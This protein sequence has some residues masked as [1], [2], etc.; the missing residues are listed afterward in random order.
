[1]T[2]PLRMRS[3]SSVGAQRSTTPIKPCPAHT[4]VARRGSSYPATLPAPARA[5]STEQRRKPKTE[6]VKTD[7]SIAWR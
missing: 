6:L 1:M 4:N 2:S 3:A 7:A 5:S